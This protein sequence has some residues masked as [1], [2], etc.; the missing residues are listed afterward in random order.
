[1]HWWRWLD[2]KGGTNSNNTSASGETT[3][4][5]QSSSYPMEGSGRWCSV[6]HAHTWRHQETP[7]STR[8][9]LI[10][11]TIL[12]YAMIND[13]CCFC[14][15][16]EMSQTDVYLSTSTFFLLHISKISPLFPVFFSHSEPG[17]LTTGVW[18]RQLTGP[19]IIGSCCGQCVA[20]MPGWWGTMFEWHE[21][22]SLVWDK[23]GNGN[24]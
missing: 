19:F 3:T 18:R 23:G 10:L 21:R 9:Y 15:L 4:K 24:R 22:E 12:L 13:F 14:L 5:K 2:G 17:T 6:T 1:M 16:K 11:F 7:P 8:L 20:S